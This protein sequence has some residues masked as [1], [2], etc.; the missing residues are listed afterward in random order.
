[1]KRYIRIIAEAIV[2]RYQLNVGYTTYLRSV[3]TGKEI[4]LEG[5]WRGI[6]CAEIKAKC[7]EYELDSNNI[8]KI[9]TFNG[10]PHE[11]LSYNKNLKRLL[12]CLFVMLVSCSALFGRNPIKDSR[13][14]TEFLR[15]VESIKPGA[16]RDFVKK[17][18]G[19]PYKVAF[20]Q[21]ADSCLYEQMSYLIN[22]R[23]RDCSGGISIPMTIEY[24]FIFKDGAL[25][26]VFENEMVSNSARKQKENHLTIDMFGKLKKQ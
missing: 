24:H 18:L 6:D 8:T 4:R 7:T 25:I 21:I 20:A 16:S 17:R 22:V 10:V 12:V 2:A 9:K 13:C 5:R 14:D 11:Q 15:I 1:M 3:N 23:A 26:G 19:E